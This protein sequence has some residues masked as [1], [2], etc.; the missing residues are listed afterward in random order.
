MAAWWIALCVLASMS[1]LCGCAGGPTHEADAARLQ[2]SLDQLAADPKLGDLAPNEMTRARAGLQTLQES[3][4]GDAEGAHNLYMAQRRVDTAWA[5]AQAAAMERERSA[6]DQ[7]HDHLL[8]AAA[9]RDAE[10]ARREL[11]QQRLQAQIR[12][13]EAARYAAEAE[14][15]RAAGDQA[16]QDA[17]AARAEAEQSKRIAKAQAKAAALA[18]KEAELMEAASK[19]DAHKATKPV[20]DAPAHKKSR[21]KKQ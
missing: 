10:Q 12:A 4:G 20:K 16:Q 17:E 19:A 13:E 9:R 2:R 14:S 7:E 18:R 21:R 6:L 8:L 11:E 5:A 1:V 15:A 3:H